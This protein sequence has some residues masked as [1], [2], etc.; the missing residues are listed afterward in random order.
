MNVPGSI[1]VQPMAHL[2]VAACVGNVVT[3]RFGVGEPQSVLWNDLQYHGYDTSLNLI[4][5]RTFVLSSH[6]TAEVRVRACVCHV[7]L[8]PSMVSM[9]PSAGLSWCEFCCV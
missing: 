5:A 3:V 4:G 9:Q 2:A 8:C 7:D 6:T 1:A